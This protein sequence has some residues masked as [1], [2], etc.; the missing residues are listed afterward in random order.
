M[1]SPASW[2]SRISSQALN[3][4]GA[5]SGIGRAV[6][7]HLASLGARLALTDQDAEGGKAVC[8]E[9]RQLG[10]KI[11][12]V[13]ATLDVSSEFGSEGKQGGADAGL[14][15]ADDD[16]VGKLVRTF[17]RTYKKLDGLVNCAG[18]PGGG[19]RLATEL[20][21]LFCRH[22]PPLAPCSR[23]DDGFLQQDDER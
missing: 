12:V 10:N 13:F 16:G 15:L 20:T 21:R 1:R 17:L 18:T 19:S 4:A 2:T 3:L 8:Q 23:D 7:L 14:V 11:D 5:A 22:Q 6:A 9:V